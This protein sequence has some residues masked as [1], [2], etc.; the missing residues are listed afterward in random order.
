MTILVAEDNVSLC[1]GLRLGLGKSGYTVVTVHNGEEALERIKENDIDI[2]ISDLKMP[3]MDGLALLKA[4]KD[5]NSEIYV[6]IMTAFGEVQTAVGAMKAGAYDY[7]TK[8]FSIDEIELLV[9]RIEDQQRLIEEREYLWEEAKPKYDFQNMVGSTAKMREIHDLIGKVA[10]TNASVLIRGETGTGKELVATAIHSESMRR[11]KPLIKVACSALAETLL[12]SE[13]FGHEKGSFT[14]AVARRKGR[15]ELADKGTLFLDEIGDISFGVQAKLL[16]VL[17][18]KEFERVGGTKSI[19]VDVRLISSTNKNL[20]KAV[21]EGKFREDLFYRLNVV[22]IYLPSLRERKQDIALL[23]NYFLQK[24]KQETNKKIT[25]FHPKTIEV[26]TNYDWPGN[27]RE[28]ENAVERAVVL[29]EEETILPEHLPFGLPAKPKV[30]ATVTQNQASIKDK[31]EDLE[32]QE[33]IR[34]LEKSGW[35]QSQ[36]AKLLGLSRSSMRYKMKKLRCIQQRARLPISLPVQCRMREK[37]ENHTLGE[38]TS[39]NIS[40]GGM[41][42]KWPV[43]WKCGGCIHYRESEGKAGCEVTRCI[44]EGVLVHNT[45]ALELELEFEFP[46]FPVPMKARAKVVWARETQQANN[47]DLGLQ[48]TKMG[49][50]ERN[51]INDY[52]EERLG[53]ITDEQRVR[54]E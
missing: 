2:L 23:S 16:R 10:K 49:E 26:M 6:V 40:Y 47:Y 29:S 25:G 24:F 36:A 33:V 13:L 22:P 5:I 7:I 12:E 17:Q 14:G 48:F 51:A 20:E 53:E 32:R 44:H 18:E 38:T 52:V 19:K 34:A 1:K 41:L 27:I 39:K 3:K 50:T 43:D 30:E 21:E 11:D 42:L 45:E 9:K 15:F 8:P 28:L 31:M 46:E 37:G 54:I 4:A 35:N